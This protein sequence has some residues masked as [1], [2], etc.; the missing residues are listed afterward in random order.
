MDQQLKNTPA[1]Q[2]LIPGSGRPLE[3]E[4]AT[5]LVFLAEKSQDRGA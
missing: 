3:E 1:I 4:M 5:H 2:G